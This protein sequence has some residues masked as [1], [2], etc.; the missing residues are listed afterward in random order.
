LATSLSSTNDHSRTPYFYDR[1]EHQRRNPHTDSKLECLR[2]RH[3]NTYG[4]FHGI[5]HD[6]L[7]NRWKYTFVQLFYI[8]D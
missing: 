2:E 7:Y 8:R 5:Q 3:S 1:I 6:L 4:L